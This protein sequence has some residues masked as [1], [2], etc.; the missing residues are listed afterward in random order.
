MHLL[1]DPALT[2]EQV[3]PI[4]DGIEHEIEARLPGT[5]AVIHVEPDDG[6]HAE[7]FESLVRKRSG[8]GD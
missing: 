1:V 5:I 8:A 4:S 2:V 6:L 3:H 7:E